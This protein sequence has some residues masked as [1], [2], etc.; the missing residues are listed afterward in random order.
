MAVNFPSN[1]TNGQ[2]VTVSGITYAY[3]S[4]QGVWSDSPQGLTQAIDALTDVD[5]STNAPTTGQLIQWNGT[6]WVPYTHTNGITEIDQWRLTA[7]LTSDADPLSSN[8]SRVDDASFSKVGTGMSVS[9]GV[10]S[11]PSTGLWKVSTNVSFYFTVVDLA[12]RVIIQVSSDGGSN[13]DNT[14]HFKS[15]TASDDHFAH[16][17]GECFI[18][19]TSTSNVKVRFSFTSIASGNQVIGEAARSDTYFSFMRLGD[20]Q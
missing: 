4:T 13:W 16:G 5:T 19:C 7:D 3:D 14:A 9:N 10:W 17:A 2:T 8:L 20:S 6:N 18:N 15:G 11:F 12:I 1:P